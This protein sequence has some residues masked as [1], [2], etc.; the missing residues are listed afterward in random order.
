MKSRGRS[1]G[2][3][4]SRVAPPQQPPLPSRRPRHPS[5]SRRS[6]PSTP[7]SSAITVPSA[8]LSPSFTFSST[9]LPP[10]LAGISIDALSD[11][12]VTRLCS[13][14]TVSPGFT[15]SSIT[16]TSLK[17]PMS[18]T[19][20]SMVAMDVRWVDARAGPA[21]VVGAISK[22]WTRLGPQEL[23]SN[24]EPASTPICA[25]CLALRPLP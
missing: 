12:T 21:Q 4:Q 17:S 24:S 2:R 13:A 9:I 10:A 7:S 19:R 5:A 8:T 20:S 18:G 25:I 6:P 3:A 23:L 16:S 1:R 11:S 15:S 22:S 14:F